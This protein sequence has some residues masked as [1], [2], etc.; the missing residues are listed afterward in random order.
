MAETRGESCAAPTHERNVM[1][2]TPASDPSPQEIV[3]HAI[4]PSDI[5]LPP[6]QP[7]DITAILRAQL[8]EPVM[9]PRTARE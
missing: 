4:S 9:T 6:T 2:T 3:P 5:Q 7:I 8:S 1:F